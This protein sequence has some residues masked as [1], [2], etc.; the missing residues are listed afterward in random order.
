MCVCACV[1][2]DMNKN[3][4]NKNNHCYSTFNNINKVFQRGVWKKSK[5]EK[6]RGKIENV[7]KMWLHG[8]YSNKII[9]F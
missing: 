4:S 2:E 1:K 8:I 9:K 7:Y 3:S 6:K 5:R